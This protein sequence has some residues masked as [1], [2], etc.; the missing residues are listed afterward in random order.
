MSNIE[1]IAQINLSTVI[2]SILQFSLELDDAEFYLVFAPVF[3]K[4]ANVR[5][6]VSIAVVRSYL[7]N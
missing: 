7:S 4:L 1:L 2:Y 5:V 3:A 6:R